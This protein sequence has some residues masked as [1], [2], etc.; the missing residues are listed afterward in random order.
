MKVEAQLWEFY[1]PGSVMQQFS[2]LLTNRQTKK[3]MEE[4]S[5]KHSESFTKPGHFPSPGTQSCV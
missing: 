4:T 1:F 3:Y 2:C 5:D